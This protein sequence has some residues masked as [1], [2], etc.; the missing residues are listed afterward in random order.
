MAQATRSRKGRMLDEKIEQFC[1]AS[2]DLLAGIHA[3][4]D[5]TPEGIESG[6]SK[7]GRKKKANKQ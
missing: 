5:K 6:K 4:C 2:A 3:R 7:R 1:Q